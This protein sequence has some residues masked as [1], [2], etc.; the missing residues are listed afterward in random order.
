[1]KTRLLYFL[2]HESMSMNVW[3]LSGKSHAA[4]PL[5]SADAPSVGEG[6]KHEK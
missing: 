5:S 2:F 3:P 6:E 4:G 1:M